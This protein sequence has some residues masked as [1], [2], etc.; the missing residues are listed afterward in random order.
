[1]GRLNF[2][3]LGAPCEQPEGNL[4]RRL[5]SGAPRKVIEIATNLFTGTEV[6]LVSDPSKNLPRKIAEAWLAFMDVAPRLTSVDKRRGGDAALAAYR[7][8]LSGQADPKQGIVI[9]P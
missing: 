1:M 4:R 3:L 2:A 5:I 8:M 9:V 7:E 6:A